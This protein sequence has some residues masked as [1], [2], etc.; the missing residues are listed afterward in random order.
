MPTTTQ[1]LWLSS[2]VVKEI[3]KFGGQ[4]DDMVPPFVKEKLKQNIEKGRL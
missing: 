2:S 4:Y 3:A 1:N